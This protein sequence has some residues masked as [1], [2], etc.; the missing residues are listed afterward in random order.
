[1]NFEKPTD[2][3]A[4]FREVGAYLQERLE[5]ALDDATRTCLN[6]EHFVE[7]P[8]DRTG[9]KCGLNNLMPPPSIA[10]RG[11]DNHMDKIPF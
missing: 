2:R 9:E 6:C 7:G 3:Q 8:P 5:K 11:C 4:M 10:A 1:M